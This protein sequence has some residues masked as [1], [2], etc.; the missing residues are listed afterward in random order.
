MRRI[1]FAPLIGLLMLALVGSTALAQPSG[2]AALVT[3]VP[4]TATVIDD[5]EGLQAAGDLEEGDSFDALL[6]ITQINWDEASE[7]LLFS[8][9]IVAD[10]PV[11]DLADGALLG[12]FENVPGDL[13]SGS[14]AIASIAAAQLAQQGGQCQILFLD[15]GPIFLDVL[16]LQVSLSQIELD[17]TAV[18]GPGNLL[19]NLLCAVVRLLDPPSPVD[20]LLNQLTRL[21]NRINN[22]I[23]A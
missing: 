9:E 3:E 4:F 16:G 17:I 10:G 8:G 11:G 14:A 13:A 19:G 2:R 12:T 22:L 21:L 1:L 20:N 7:T 18:Q 15:L 23:G 5:S 6:T